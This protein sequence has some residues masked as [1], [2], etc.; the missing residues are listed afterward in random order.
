MSVLPD[1]GASRAVL[2]GSS[3]FDHLEPLPAVTNNLAALAEALASPT[4]WQLRPEHCVILANPG[5]TDEVMA[6]LR[7]AALEARDTL[8]VYY[9][10]HGLVDLQSRL[11]L[12]LPKSQQDWPESS[13]HY[14]WLRQ[15][16]LAGRSER[17][18]LLLDCCFSG[19][20][21]GTMAGGPPKLVDHASVEGSYLLAASSE[22]SAALAPPGETYTAFTG[23]L[24]E[25]LRSGIVGGPELLELDAVYRHLRVALAA[26]SRPEP[27]ARNRNT[28][29]RLALGRN[30]A[31]DPDLPVGMSGGLDPSLRAWPSPGGIRTA[32]G[33][34]TRL[35]DVR[36]VSG[37]SQK[38][39]SQRSGRKI[40]DGTVSNL[41]NRETLPRTWTAIPTYLS[42]CGVPE[43]QVRQWKEVWERIRAEQADSVRDLTPS[44]AEDRKPQT[45]ARRLWRRKDGSTVRPERG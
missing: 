7:A 44:A 43:D 17:Q 3:R 24:L 34:I 1:P 5:S 13:L 20:A 23:Q 28:G 25:V 37:L 11:Q 10:G 18:V 29:A 41:L 32:E 38:A 31:F 42:A 26:Q 16:V 12:A 19:L 8:L 39:I 33:F 9:A 35:G 2:I 14:E 30:R 15:A 36:V 27:Q 6:A 21:L 22:T 40:A 4:S 45:W